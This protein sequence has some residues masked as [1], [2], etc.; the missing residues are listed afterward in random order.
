MSRMCFSP[1]SSMAA[2]FEQLC[3]AVSSVGLATQA[4]LLFSKLTI[5]QRSLKSLSR[6]LTLTAR[7]ETRLMN[8]SVC[9]NKPCF[10]QSH[11]DPHSRGIAGY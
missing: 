6:V 4:L 11:G 5:L 9:L 1:S 2:G 3:V 8:H 7:G 10:L